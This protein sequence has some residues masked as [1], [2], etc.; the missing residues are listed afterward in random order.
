MI[1][2]SFGKQD[3]EFGRCLA[4]RGTIKRLDTL[5]IFAEQGCFVGTFVTLLL[6]FGKYCYSSLPP[7]Y[8]Q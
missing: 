5:L 6:N 2:L 8:P 1:G 7:A 3:E 4:F